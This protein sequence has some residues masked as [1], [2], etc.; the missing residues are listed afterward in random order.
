MLKLFLSR[1]NAGKRF[2]CRRACFWEG[3]GPPE[4]FPC[5][6]GLREA[7]MLENYKVRILIVEDSQ[8]LSAVYAAVARQLEA[9]V[10][11]AD[12]GTQAMSIINEF[13]P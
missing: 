4:R 10:R 11:V 9:A 13:Q 12:T 7:I 3:T 8:S 5:K 1:Y 2:L 6:T